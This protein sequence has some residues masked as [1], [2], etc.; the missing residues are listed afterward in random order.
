[1]ESNTAKKTAEMVKI[2]GYTVRAGSKRHQILV[3]QKKH[4]DDLAVSEV[5]A[6]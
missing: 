3:A 1:M 2:L 4:F 5:A 6:K